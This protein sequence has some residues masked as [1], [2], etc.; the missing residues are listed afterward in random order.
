[1][2]SIAISG[3]KLAGD[4]KSPI[5]SKK[6]NRM[7]II[8]FNGIILITLAIFLYLKSTKEEFDTQFWLAQI[9]ELILGSINLT[10]ISLN[11]KL[12]LVLSGR[13]KKRVTTKEL[14]T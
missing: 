14:S 9:I 7:K 13:F 11:I 4:L 10:L 2:P 8:A 12:G 3:I 5:I 1:M 6:L